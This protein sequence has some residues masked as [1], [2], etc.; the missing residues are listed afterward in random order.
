MKSE[1]EV[2]TAIQRK[3]SDIQTL[4]DKQAAI[5][6]KPNK[7]DAEVWEHKSYAHEIAK[8]KSAVDALRWALG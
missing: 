1:V 6:N 7:S 5:M 3:E 8:A 4:K 2:K